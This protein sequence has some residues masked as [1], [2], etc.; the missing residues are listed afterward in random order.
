VWPEAS[1]P[2]AEAAWGRRDAAPD[3]LVAEVVRADGALSGLADEWRTL[4]SESATNEPT[5]SPLWLE[6]WWHVFGSSRELRLI[7]LRH[8]GR[9]VGV[10]PL[11]L[12]TRWARPGIPYRRLEF[13]GSG[14][15]EADE[16]FSEY[17]GVVARSGMEEAVCLRAVEALCTGVLGHWD[18]LVCERMRGDAPSTRAWLTALRHHGLSPVM[19]KERPTHYVALPATWEA[20]L[21]QLSSSKRYRIRRSLKDF[22]G[23][24]GREPVLRRVEKREQVEEALQALARFGAERR[25]ERQVEMQTQ[26]KV[27]AMRR[28]PGGGSRPVPGRHHHA[29]RRQPSRRCEFAD[30]ARDAIG[31]RIVI[32]A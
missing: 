31:Q 11:S 9:L 8:L 2:A 20:F 26:R 29:G 24:V 6:P 21:A 4:L 5:L 17:I 25:A 22:Q 14:E 23:W 32:G 18:E 16:I 1:D 28:K 30:R 12:R 3:D 15:P 7:C 13:L 19:T 10:V 27:P